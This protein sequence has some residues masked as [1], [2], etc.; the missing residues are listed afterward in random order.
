MYTYAFILI[1]VCHACVYV[2][3]TLIF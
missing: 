2:L 1:V 3:A